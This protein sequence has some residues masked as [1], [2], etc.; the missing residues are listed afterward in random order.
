MNNVAPPKEEPQPATVARQ[1]LPA[2]APPAKIPL[3][4]CAELVQRPKSLGASYFDAYDFQPATQPPTPQQQPHI[5]QE[6]AHLVS[7]DCCLLGC[8][9][10]LRAN[11]SCYSPACLAE[12]EAVIQKF[13]GRC[14]PDYDD[15][16]AHLITHVVCPDRFSEAYRRVKLIDTG[17][18]ALRKS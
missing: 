6:N 1:S 4:I 8:V 2:A 7:F 3:P 9:F 16:H 14:V 13:G 10:Y 18:E 15:A 5:V 17:N 12:W 11:E